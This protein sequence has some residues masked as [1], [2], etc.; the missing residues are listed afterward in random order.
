MISK[1][2]LVARIN[3]VSNDP[4]ISTI[5]DHLLDQVAGGLGTCTPFHDVFRDAYRDGPI[6]G[7]TFTDVFNEC[8]TSS[9]SDS[10]LSNMI[11]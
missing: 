11:S 4:K 10:K 8:P 6:V 7:P 5:P 2:N 3:A 9:E 1:E